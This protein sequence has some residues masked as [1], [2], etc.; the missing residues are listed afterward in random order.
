[1]RELIEI[2]TRGISEEQ[3]VD[4]LCVICFFSFNSANTQ[5]AS[6]ACT[7]L[8]LT[9][10]TRA[11][12]GTAASFLSEDIKVEKTLSVLKQKIEK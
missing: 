1:M 5:I 3:L 12:A 2:S 9:W 8:Q 6:L 10:K 4:S 11:A 7:Q